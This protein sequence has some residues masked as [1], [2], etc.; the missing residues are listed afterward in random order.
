MKYPKTFSTY[1]AILLWL[2]IIL[3]GCNVN[4]GVTEVENVKVML[5]GKVFHGETGEEVSN[6]VISIYESVR[7]GDGKYD[8]RDFERASVVT[9]SYGNY[10]LKGM[11]RNCNLDEMGGS[12]KAEKTDATG[13]TMTYTGEFRCSEKLQTRNLIL[14]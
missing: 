8:F 14:R 13:K 12:I 6:A 1:S 4:D 7:N 11:I 5:R 9:D 3:A 10:H 2:V